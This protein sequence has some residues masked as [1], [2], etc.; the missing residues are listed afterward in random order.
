LSLNESLTTRE[1]KS[2]TALE[3]MID[4]LESELAASQHQQEEMVYY[5]VMRY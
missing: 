2:T 1:G 3:S 5:P 4:R